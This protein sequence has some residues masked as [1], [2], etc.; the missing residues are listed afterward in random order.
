MAASSSPPLLDRI[1]DSAKRLFGNVN[2]SLI[3]APDV[4]L[5]AGLNVQDK[6]H[7]S[8]VPQ[9]VTDTKWLLSLTGSEDSLVH[10]IAIQSSLELQ[11]VPADAE[12]FVVGE[13]WKNKVL[14]V[15]ELTA[16]EAH[17]TA[18]NEYRRT[19][20]AKQHEFWTNP[21]YKAKY[22]AQF[23]AQFR[24]QN[25]YGCYTVEDVAYDD[26]MPKLEDFCLQPG[27]PLFVAER[28][29][30]THSVQACA[31]YMALYRAYANHGEVMLSPDDVWLMIQLSF[32][33]YVN[34]CPENAERLRP[35]LVHHEGKK[36]IEVVIPAPV[37][38]IGNQGYKNLPWTSFC[39]AVLN[40]MQ[41][42]MKNGAPEKL[43]ADFSTTTSY[44]RLVSS[45]VVMDSFKAYFEYVMRMSCGIT[46]VHMGGTLEDWEKLEAK[47]AALRVFAEPEPQT[48]AERLEREKRTRWSDRTWTGY[49][50]RLA[51]VLNKFTETFRGQVDVDWWNRV[52]NE[53]HSQ[54]Y[55]FDQSSLTGWATNF[56]FGIP[57]QPEDLASIGDVFAR[58]PVT[59]N[60]HGKMIDIEMLTGFD[61]LTIY[62]G[63]VLRPHTSVSVLTK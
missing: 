2:D 45:V 41:S 44:E 11:A 19:W 15:G 59:I 6:P 29:S 27:E 35:L 21:E 22:D 37:G 26:N 42:Q 17:R 48:D 10:T 20:R 61:G 12:A 5:L 25:R 23:M 16:E 52:V 50:D 62:K 8:V 54:G 43:L 39:D 24:E 46:K 47:L 28:F 1:R 32:S 55:G 56:I 13:H 18:M 33:R 58:C 14:S 38:S 51:P 3:D 60:D 9:R 57:N 40:E 7:V 30:G 36:V 53:K 4:K 63:R 31:F 34:L 49:L